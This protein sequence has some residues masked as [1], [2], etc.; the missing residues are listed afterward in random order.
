M[1][2]VSL[3]LAL[4]LASCADLACGPFGPNSRPNL[5][6]QLFF[7]RGTVPDDAFARFAADT[8]TPAF[9]DGFTLLDATGQWRGPDGISR[10]NTKLLIVSAP[11]T[12]AFRAAI[13]QVE[14]AYKTQFHQISVGEVFSYGCAAF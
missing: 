14:D 8:I 1:S 11:D 9:P 13:K 10:E 4:L 7:G 12:Q 5:V 2:R 3:L 6:A